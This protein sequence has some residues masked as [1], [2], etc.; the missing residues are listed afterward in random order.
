MLNSW[1]EYQN[2]LNAMTD[3]EVA[4]ETRRM[5]D[6]AVEAEAWLEAVAAW[7]AAGR[8]RCKSRLTAERRS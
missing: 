2:D 8:P 5:E 3:E 4:E 7:D 1:F 6:Q